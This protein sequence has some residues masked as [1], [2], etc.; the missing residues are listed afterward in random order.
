MERRTFKAHAALLR[1]VI[2]NQSSTLPKAVLEAVMNSV[3]AGAST[4]AIAV[5]MKNVRIVDD[6]RGFQSKDDIYAFFEMFGTPHVAGD[7][8]FGRFRMGRGQLFNMGRNVWRSNGF[9]LD[10]NIGVDDGGCEAEDFNYTIEDDKK[11]GPGCEIDVELYQPMDSY[12]MGQIERE[13]T[14]YVKYVSTEITINGHVVNKNPEKA[15][16][17]LQTDQAYFL[18]NREGRGLTIYNQ[19]A[20]VQVC[21]RNTFGVGGVVVS[22]KRLGVNFARNEILTICPEWKAIKATLRAHG[23]AEVK[24][25]AKLTEDEMEA[26]GPQLVSGIVNWGGHYGTKLFRFSDESCHSFNDLMRKMAKRGLRYSFAEVGDRVADKLLQQELAVILDASSFEQ[27]GVDAS[28]PGTFF[29][30][31]FKHSGCP[32]QWKHAP[33]QVLAKAIDSNGTIVPAAKMSV[34]EVILVSQLQ[35]LSDWISYQMYGDTDERRKLF[36]GKSDVSAA[37]TDG[38]SHVVLTRQTIKKWGLDVEGFSKY[39][40]ILLHELCHGEPDSGTHTHSRDFYAL[41]EK[42]SY[43]VAGYGI[44]F[45]GYYQGAIVKAGKMADKRTRQR[46]FRAQEAEMY[47]ARLAA[48]A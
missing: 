25:K 28:S 8:V 3:D 7:A 4:I 11:A 40:L 47:R 33:L 1:S 29:Q 44:Q 37:W 24:R 45:H 14:H 21:A 23:E 13:L 39:A 43:E 9:V 31:I 5:D 27:F 41:F 18:L 38:Q 46:A 35:R 20:L 22:K 32:V 10:V 26:L 48:S 15:R 6:G 16:W 17:T 36:I 30:Q 42:H 34:T 2:R 12:L 19:G